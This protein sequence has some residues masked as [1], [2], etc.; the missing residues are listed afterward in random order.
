MPAIN[1]LESAVCDLSG[2]Q[3]TVAGVFRLNAPKSSGPIF[4]DKLLCEFCMAYPDVDVELT[5]DDKKAV[6]MAFGVDAA[7][8]SQ[9]L[10]EM[11]TH[12]VAIGPALKMA[13]VASPAYLENHGVPETPEDLAAHVDI[14][15]AIGNSRHLVP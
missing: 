10:L 1:G 7:I 13:I 9:N 3:R 12:A 8:R 5:L 4:L 11:E 2:A 15:F 14:H 6:L